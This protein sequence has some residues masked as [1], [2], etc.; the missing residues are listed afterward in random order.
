M[1]SAARA[2]PS[3]R[4]VWL[5]LARASSIVL[6]VVYHVA[7]GAGPDLLGSDERLSGRIWAQANS[8]LVP[9]RMPL[10]FAVS[11]ILAFRAVHR[12]WRAVLR[13]RV[14]DLL[15]PYAL[16]SLAFALTA[17]PRY[18]PDAAARFARDE[19]VATLVAASP[20]WFIA[21]LPLV[22][23]ITRLCR[24]RSAQLLVVALLAYAAAPFIHREMLAAELSADLAY[25][26]FQV[27]DNT[28]W[29]VLGF[30]VRD[31]FSTLGE[32]SR[33]LAGALLAGVFA[34]LA[35]AI[36]LAD[37][38]LAVTR[39]MELLASLS[40]LLACVFLLPALGRLP[41]AARLGHQLGRRTLVIY[42]VHPLVLNVIVVLWRISSAE[43]WMA[44][45]LRICLLVPVVTVLSI[46]AALLV[47]AWVARHGPRWLLAAPGG[48]VTHGRS[49]ASRVVS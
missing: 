28:V 6:V 17:W 40:G 37:V 41:A 30:V 9:L 29:F 5:D 10:F 47:D 24:A 21:V 34:V 45:I 16:W 4:I 43:E 19:V 15:W 23:L 35:A 31:R 13:P 33:P 25:G 8:A 42:L 20:Y 1:S 18:A 27:L 22:F 12:P 38:P 7:V 39:S 2:A 3:G 46:W 11:G 32:R 48:R 26:V 49:G 14:L 44:P 36:L